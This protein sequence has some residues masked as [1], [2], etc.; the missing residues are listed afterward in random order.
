MPVKAR[1]GHQ[2]LWYW[3][4][5]QLWATWWGCWE[6]NPGRLKEQKCFELESS[7]WFFILPLHRISVWISRSSRS[8]SLCL[9]A[10]SFSLSTEMNHN[11]KVYSQTVPE[12]NLQ[13]WGKDLQAEAQAGAPFPARVSGSIFKK[14]TCFGRQRKTAWHYRWH[15]SPEREI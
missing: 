5:T 4:D 15:M 13:H 1:R 11:W 12:E 3:S 6:P 14:L 9:F 2:S 7:V 10:N 8:F